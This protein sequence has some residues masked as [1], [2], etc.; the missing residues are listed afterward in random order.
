MPRKK[1]SFTQ[2]VGRFVRNSLLLLISVG[3]FSAGVFLLWV[4]SLK[5]PNLDGLFEER[6]IVASTKIYD[7]TGEV[8]LFDVHEDIK[9]TIIPYEE[10][11]DYAKQAVIAIEDDEFYE[12]KGIDWRAT[13]RGILLTGMDYLGLEGG[14]VQGGSTITQQVIKNTLLTREKRI[15]RKFKEWALALKLEQKLTKDE[16][17]SLYL[18]E[19]PY[20]GT[21]YGIEQAS[22]VFFKK[23]A[24]DLTV[25]E[26]AYL[27]AIIN[28]P[29]FY[30]PYGNNRE[31]LEE[32]KDSVLQKMFIFDMIT[33]DEFA[34]ALT[35]EVVFHSRVESGIKAPHFVQ[36]VREQL[37]DRYGADMVLNGGL[38]VITTLDWDLQQK[39]EEIVKRNALENEKNWDA[40][41]AGLIAIEN[42]TG[43]IITMVG[44]RDYFDAEVD[45]NFNVTLAKRQPGSSFKPFV[46][47]AAF[48]K[49]YTP[50]TVLFDTRT[51]FSNASECEIDFFS[52]EGE[53]YSPA[54]YDNKYQGPISLRNAL[55]QSRNVPAVKLLY[56]VGA[57]KALQTARSLGI[58]TL[59]KNPEH[60]G[61]TLVLGGGEVSLLEM[62]SAYSTFPN[63]G[64]HYETNPIIS[65]TSRDN[66]INDRFGG[67]SRQ[68]ISP[69]VART[70]SDVLGDNV[71]RTPLF[72][73]RS[74]LYF[75]ADKDVAGKTGTTND[76]RDAWL[77]GYNSEVTVGVWSGNPDNSPMK[78][79][80]SISGR[81]W[82][83]FMDEVHQT[84]DTSLFN[85]PPRVS[86]ETKPILR[87]VW[88]GG[89]T[90]TIDRISGKLATELTPEETKEEL[91]IPDPHS[92]L[93]WVDKKDPTGDAPTDP[94]RDNQYLR[95]ELPVINWVNENR[96][97][98]LLSSIVIPTEYDD[99]HTPENKPNFSLVSPLAG[100]V[101]NRNQVINI[102]PG[103]ITSNF[104]IQEVLFFVNGSL[105]GSSQQQPFST[106]FI[107][108]NFSEIGSGKNTL[109]V[110]VKDQAFNSRR[111]SQELLIN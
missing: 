69:E 65:V 3:L 29:T 18:N 50:D 99:V 6:K 110:V 36:Y 90:A 52:S 12:H 104:P 101:Y 75:G 14:D 95:W 28:A 27:A 15:S 46:Y 109:E 84:Y 25:A 108:A 20:G 7:K 19:V 63:E 11:A 59:T 74:F 82:R 64:T 34:E 61:L 37:E 70:V 1:R 33:K 62:A 86:E 93:H 13:G 67:R 73:S 58:S 77:V 57:D 80:S 94:T 23:P 102:N 5:I 111:I 4:S 41:N 105:I 79:G 56:L 48:E 47:A 51:Q 60:Y 22:Q 44:S 98:L 30:S 26:S 100:S 89:K 96:P 66:S 43:N 21:I 32:R 106:S 97:D 85:P 10:I 35:E 9:R 39:A 68:V 38:E 91:T 72:G 45:G 17:L 24:L 103:Q 54:N 107:P 31:K 8:L 81:P 71:A 92:I 42:K 49:G 87:G 76:N 2:K 78:K 16:I 53:C 55:A 88:E 83:E 40:S